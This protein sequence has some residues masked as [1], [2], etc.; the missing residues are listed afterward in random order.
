MQRFLKRIIDVVGAISALVVFAPLMFVVALLVRAKLGAPVFYRQDRVG[1]HEKVFRLWKFR[2]MTDAR[3]A[4]GRL[5][6]DGDRLTPFG[7]RIRRWSLDELPQLFNVLGGS[8]S[9]VGPRPLLVRYLPRYTPEQRR[10]HL[11]KPGITGLAQVSGRNGLS[12]DERFALDV[13][14]VDNWSVWLDIRILLRTVLQLFKH[15]G[16]G[17][18]AGAE[19][20]EFWGSLKPPEGGPPALP[21]E[22]RES[23]S[24][25][26]NLG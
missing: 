25:H 8:L 11:I 22:E 15:S 20:P 16:S 4:A 18:R 17:A 19:N 12:W 3:D 26:R 21:V 7:L 6:P 9:L 24:L 14:Y 10:R 13:Q 5:L 23:L 1:L 2:T